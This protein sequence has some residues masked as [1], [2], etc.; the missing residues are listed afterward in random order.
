MERVKQDF[1]MNCNAVTIGGPGKETRFSRPTERHDSV[2]QIHDTD[3][4]DT[5]VYLAWERCYRDW[6]NQRVRCNDYA[7]SLLEKKSIRT[8]HKPASIS[9]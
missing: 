4:A 5:V 6:L 3:L 8:P 2:F 7:P 9:P 1:E